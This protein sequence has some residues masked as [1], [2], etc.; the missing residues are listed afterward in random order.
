[1]TVEI[2]GGGRKLAEV[3]VGIEVRGPQLKLV[4]QR[5]DQAA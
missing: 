1:L 3:E 2:R 5:W 4:E